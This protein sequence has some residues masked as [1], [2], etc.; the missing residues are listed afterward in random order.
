MLFSVKV[1]SNLMLARRWFPSSISSAAAFIS[2]ATLSISSASSVFVQ[3]NRSLGLTRSPPSHVSALPDSWM[4][5]RDL[6]MISLN[7]V[8]AFENPAIG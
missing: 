6:L 7:F 1:Q 8:Y 5:R 2:W 4:V 3:M